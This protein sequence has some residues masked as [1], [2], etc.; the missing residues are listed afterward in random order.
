MGNWEDKTRASLLAV[1]IL[2]WITL[3]SIG[4]L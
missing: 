1:L 2:G 4:I 3:V